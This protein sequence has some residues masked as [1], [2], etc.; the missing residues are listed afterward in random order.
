MR[1]TTILFI[2]AAVAAAH[3][4]VFYFLA[5]TN[6]LPKVP[7][8]PPADFTAGAAEFT[9]PA[10]HEKMLYQEFTVSSRVAPGVSP[11]Q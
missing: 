6:P 10:T 5:G 9:D 8:V 11:A 3:A 1:R 2:A 4:A 7:Y